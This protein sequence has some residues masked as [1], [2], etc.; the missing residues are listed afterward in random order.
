M[1]QEPQA[2][3]G[4]LNA[5]FPSAQTLINNVA[6][7]VGLNSSAAP[8][9]STDPNFVQLQVLANKLGKQ[10]LRRNE[11]Q[12]LN[13]TFTFTTVNTGPPTPQVS[14]YP[15]PVDFN[16]IINQ[17]AWNRT[18]RLPMAGPLTA[19]GWEWL[20]GLVSNQYTI[21]LGFRQWQGTFAVYPSP[22]PASQTIAFEYQSNA[23]VQPAGTNTTDQRQQT[24]QS[25]GDL[26]LFDEMMFQCGLKAAFLAAKG[27]DSTAAAQEFERA[28]D[29]AV[30]TDAGAPKIN[31]S[32]NGFG[33][34]YLDALNNVP[35]SGF[36]QP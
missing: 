9:S 33:M 12:L 7:E 17:T 19:Q 22:N 20:V 1:P 24:L 16:R 29:F 21:Y 25:P 34:R 13:R 11:W 14:F 27:F 18:S 32:D 2:T 26:V 4:W 5:Q 23:W 28:V 30:G 36:G 15:L 3:I 10:L 35:P 8:L 6:V 31:M